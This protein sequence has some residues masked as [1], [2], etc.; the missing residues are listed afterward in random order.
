MGFLIALTGGIGSG[1][2]AAADHFLQHGVDVIDTDAIAH[3]L[4]AKDGIALPALHQAFGTTIFLPDGTLNRAALRQ[5]V[6]SQPH[7]KHQL[8]QILHP[9]IRTATA[10]ALATC[11]GSYQLIAV[12]LL[13]ETGFYR[14]QAQRVCVV[15]CP[16]A[17]QITRVKAR[18]GFSDAQ[19]SAIMAQQASRTQRLAAADDVLDNSGTLDALHQQIDKLH[20]QYLQ[21]AA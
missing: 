20:W 19:V 3:A 5:R 12:P 10:Q 6:F 7:A 17:L 15:D 4:T 1:K 2:S 14:Q 9:L 21:Y 13:V 18:N 16:E 11:A 8:E